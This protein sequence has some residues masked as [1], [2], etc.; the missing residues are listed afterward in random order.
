MA[1]PYLPHEIV[2]R[3]KRGFGA[4]MEEWFQE[5]DFGSRC[6]AA[7]ER[8]VLVKEGFLDKDYF[9]GLLGQ[10]MKGG[11]GHSFHLWTV[12]NAVLW[13]ESWIEG[14]EDCF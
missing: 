8:S 6:L 1:E 10:Q 11:G 9:R 12:M 2:Y 14:R 4:P 3:P 5:G 7:F 13:H